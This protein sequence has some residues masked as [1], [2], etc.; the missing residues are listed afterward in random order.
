[1]LCSLMLITVGP[2]IAVAQDY[3]RTSWLTTV[4]PTIDG[5]WTSLDEWTDGEETWIGT[6]LFL[7]STRDGRM[8]RWIVEFISDTTDDAGDYLQLCGDLTQYGG[9]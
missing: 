3:T 7:T 9:S 5:E 8:T 1:M 4:T 6:D 2:T